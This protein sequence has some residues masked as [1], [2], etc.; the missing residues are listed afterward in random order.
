MDEQLASMQSKVALK[1]PVA[2]LFNK[3]LS[4]KRYKYQKL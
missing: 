1:Q 4:S 3:I 2:A